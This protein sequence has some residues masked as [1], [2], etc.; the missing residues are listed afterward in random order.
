MLYQSTVHPGGSFSLAEMAACLCSLSFHFLCHPLPS[1]PFGCYLLCF[2][3]FFC[4]F[5]STNK[6]R[7]VSLHSQHCVAGLQIAVLSCQEVFFLGI[8]FWVFIWTVNCELLSVQLSPLLCHFLPFFHTGWLI[9]PNIT[10]QLMLLWPLF[11]CS[12]LS[13]WAS[14]VD[15]NGP[16]S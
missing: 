6:Q 1:S 8:R 15:Q 12:S 10:Q 11:S 7:S 9:Y 2:A 14:S 5:S 3:H 16:M 13:L 4:P